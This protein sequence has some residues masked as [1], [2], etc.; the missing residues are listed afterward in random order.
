MIDTN[1]LDEFTRK[2]VSAIPQSILAAQRDL[3]KN[4]RASL[5][6]LFR[7]LDLVTREEY[8]VQVALLE[9]STERLKALEARISELERSAGLTRSLPQND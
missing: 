6:S 8:E 9:K 2:L 5:E 3:E 1:T 4:L 7:K